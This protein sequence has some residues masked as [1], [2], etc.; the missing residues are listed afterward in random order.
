MKTIIQAIITDS[1]D[2]ASQCHTHY[3]EAFGSN[4]HGSTSDQFKAFERGWLLSEVSKLRKAVLMADAILERDGIRPLK[5]EAFTSDE[6]A[7]IQ[8]ACE[9]IKV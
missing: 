2:I 5:G 4:R 6:L 7:V 9:L 8:K 3:V 1:S